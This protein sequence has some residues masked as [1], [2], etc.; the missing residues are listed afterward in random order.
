MKNI[1]MRYWIESKGNETDNASLKDVS[2]I[3]PKDVLKEKIDISRR[4]TKHYWWIKVD[5]T[6]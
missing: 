1:K 4:K 5:I 3:S 2:R 6:I